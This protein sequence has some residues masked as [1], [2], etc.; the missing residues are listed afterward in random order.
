MHKTA[1]TICLLPVALLIVA[2]VGFSLWGGMGAPGN[3]PAQA[4]PARIVTLGPSAAEII[5]LLGACDHVV[6]VSR[7][8]THPPELQDLPRIGGLVDPDLERIVALRPDLVVLR[9]NSEAVTALCSKLGIRVYL[10]RTETLADIQTTINE[11]G[12]ILQRSGQARQLA[13]EF[14][15]RLSSIRATGARHA[16]PR[17]L[18]TVSRRP[19]RLADVLTA[20]K[21]TF[22]SEAVAIAGGTNVFGH[23]DLA[24]PQVSLESIVAAAPDVIIEFMPG[25]EVTDDDLATFKTQWQSLGPTPAGDTGCI[26]AITADHALMP[27]PRFVGIVETMATMLHPEDTTGA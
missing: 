4:I 24:Y 19:D 10:D 20:G 8:C 2:G 18:L 23:L 13:T 5:C 16:P 15:A 1:R 6:G 14:Q 7:Y 11:L 26:H 3:H 17:V 27:S 25:A 9:G 12:G 22:L 21:G